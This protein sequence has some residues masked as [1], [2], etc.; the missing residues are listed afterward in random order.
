MPALIWLLQAIYVISKQIK[1]VKLCVSETERG[2]A[3]V[4]YAYSFIFWNINK[5]FER[6]RVYI[7]RM[8]Q[9]GSQLSL[10]PPL[11]LL[12]HSLGFALNF[13]HKSPS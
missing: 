10:P 12:Y 2:N 13:G 3:N 11:T 5:S 7:L 4:I 9:H 1:F 8:H 6:K